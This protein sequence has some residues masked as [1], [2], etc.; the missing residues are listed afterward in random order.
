[1][2]LTKYFPL[3]IVIFVL[4][5]LLIVFLP[6]WIRL[7]SFQSSLRKF[8][9]LVKEG[10]IYDSADFVTKS[11]YQQAIQIIEDHVYPGYENDIKALNINRIEK[12]PKGYLATLVVRLEGA[13]YTWVGRAKMLWTKE[14]NDW[15]FSLSDVAV[16][17]LLS[18]NWVTLGQVLRSSSDDF[19]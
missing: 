7:L 4:A 15:R 19:E 6:G 13:N 14:G 2:K 1:M 10:K 11:E 8:I 16:A 5:F 18:E 3:F 12:V 9:H 17:E